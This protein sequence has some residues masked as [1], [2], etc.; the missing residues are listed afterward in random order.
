MA[1]DRLSLRSY[2]TLNT[3]IVLALPNQA[4]SQETRSLESLT[5]DVR[6]RSCPDEG[7]RVSETTFKE[8]GCKTI[9]VDKS[10]NGGNCGEG[11]LVGY[12]SAC[13]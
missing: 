6:R 11:G 1:L 8:A 9:C 13:Q 10:R 12:D 7:T 4:S 3:A 5:S 2:A